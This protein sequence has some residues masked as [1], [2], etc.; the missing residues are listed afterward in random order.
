[1]RNYFL[2]FFLNVLL[3]FGQPTD[4]DYR[5]RSQIYSDPNKAI[6]SL[7]SLINKSKVPGDKLKYYL[8]LSTA[9]TSKRDLDK[10]FESIKKA[11]DLLKY[12]NDDKAKA[13]VLLNIAI[14]YQQ[15]ELFS[16]SFDNLE[17]AES[18]A[19]KLPD[20]MVIK[21]S[22]LG[23]IYGIRGTNYRIQDNP[24]L[25]LEKF[26]KSIWYF[27]KY[28]KGVFRESNL[29]VIYYNVGYCYL[30][31]KNFDKAK[32]SF[33]ESL[34]LATNNKALS[35]EAYALK[36]LGELYFY[37]QDYSQALNYLD[38]AEAKASNVRDLTLDN[39]IY[40][41]KANNYL[42]LKQTDLYRDY[43]EKYQ[44]VVSQKQESEMAIIGKS[45]DDMR[46]ANR[47]I[48]NENIASSQ[49]LNIV[50]IVVNFLVLAIIG[51]FISKRLKINRLL[52]KDINEKFSQRKLSSFSN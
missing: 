28:K 16:N 20:T 17:S 38:Q 19:V 24:E 45:I 32:S 21:F 22:T 50:I 36:G 15:M 35:L 51:F 48:I 3:V 29:S 23:M 46:E 30:E 40:L 4:L 12:I 33:L 42:A 25:A 41:L 6:F 49:R 13:S 27:N 52:A 5:I 43:Y 37:E 44:A 47:L 2:F 31:L 10:S 39:G 14:Q 34:E 18:L 7:D 9:Y 1:M 26:Y 8:L 11:Q